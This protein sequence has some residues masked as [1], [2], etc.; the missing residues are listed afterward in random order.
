M[1]RKNPLPPLRKIRDTL[2]TMD[3]NRDDLVE[4]RDWL[5]RE[6]AARG[7]TESQIAEAAGLSP[8]RVNQIKHRR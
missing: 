2:A 3:L 4:G 8:G 1:L 5:I 6:A 7:K